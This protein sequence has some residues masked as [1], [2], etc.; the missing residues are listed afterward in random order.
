MERCPT[1]PP[2]CGQGGIAIHFLA[3]ARGTAEPLSA[4]HVNEGSPWFEEEA[5]GP[6]DI[7]LLISTKKNQQPLP[8]EQRLLEMLDATL[9]RM[10]FRLK[11]IIN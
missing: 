9:A 1:D 5:E 4:Y 2:P 3:D 10:M 11:T 6:S 8:D 7:G